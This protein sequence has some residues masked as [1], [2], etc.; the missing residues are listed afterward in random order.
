M[1]G[2]ARVG[3]GGG[4]SNGAAPWGSEWWGAVDQKEARL[5]GLRLCGE[6]GSQRSG[7]R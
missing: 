2:A 5:T 4:S 1:K 3:F 6:G 7:T